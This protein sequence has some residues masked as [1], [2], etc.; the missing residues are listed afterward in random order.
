MPKREPPPERFCNQ[1]LFKELRPSFQVRS[2]FGPRA[3]GEF[4]QR[5]LW[6]KIANPGRSPVYG[7]VEKTGACFPFATR[8]TRPEASLCERAYRETKPN[9][10]GMARKDAKAQRR[11]GRQK[12]GCGR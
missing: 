3:E 6:S 4:L 12:E 1:L 7:E 8:E 5:L 10:E 9:G 11:G 2:P